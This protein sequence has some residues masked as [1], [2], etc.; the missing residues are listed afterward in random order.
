MTVTPTVP[1]KPIPAS[2]WAKTPVAPLPVVITSPLHVR[3]RSPP[4]PMPP[5]LPANRASTTPPPPPILWTKAPNAPAPRVITVPDC[6]RLIEPPEPMPS[7]L[8]VRLS[9][10]VFKSENTLPPPPPTVC[11]NT[12]C[13]CTPT[14]EIKPL[15][16]IRISPP[17]PVAP[18]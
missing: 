14:V 11:R 8:S 13:D 5:A 3:L 15:L 16:L 1:P 7:V 17:F 10:A 18:D 6:R 2:L 12:P 9:A 4:L